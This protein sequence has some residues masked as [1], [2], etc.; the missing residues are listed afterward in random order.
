MQTFLL[1]RHIITY[2]YF[3]LVTLMSV[4]IK[5][6]G[7]LYLILYEYTLIHYFPELSNII[8]NNVIFQKDYLF[9]Y[10]LTIYL[11]AH[12]LS[13]SLSLIQKLVLSLDSSLES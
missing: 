10:Q 6:V 3:S 1:Y 4:K 5:R 12:T 13:F 8:I 11:F 7:N 2:I 9:L